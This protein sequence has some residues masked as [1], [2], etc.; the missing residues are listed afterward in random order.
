MF[1]CLDFVCLVYFSLDPG[2]V[3]EAEA[4][5]VCVA[6]SLEPCASSRLPPPLGS[7]ARGSSWKKHGVSPLSPLDSFKCGRAGIYQGSEMGEAFY[8]CSFQS[9]C[10]T[11]L[12]IAT[13]RF[14]L[15][16]C[17]EMKLSAAS[18]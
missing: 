14:R 1:S 16:R 2:R 7:P 11:C 12:I 3:W 15:L 17:T 10:E 9:P 18:E 8:S 13:L 6:S 5:L 4:G